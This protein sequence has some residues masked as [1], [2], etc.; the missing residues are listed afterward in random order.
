MNTQVIS[1]RLFTEEVLQLRQ[2]KKIKKKNKK[3]KIKIKK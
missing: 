3:I 2:K 1:Y